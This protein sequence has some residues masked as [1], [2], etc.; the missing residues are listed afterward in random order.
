MTL[1][2][3][4]LCAIAL[5]IVFFKITELNHNIEKLSGSLSEIKSIL[6]KLTTQ[7]ISV[8]KKIV[9]QEIQKE[10][11]QIED[12]PVMPQKTQTMPLENQETQIGRAHV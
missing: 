10:K 9:T 2:A 8:E 1:L 7:E 11:T 5:F 6:K 4:I 3:I 12:V